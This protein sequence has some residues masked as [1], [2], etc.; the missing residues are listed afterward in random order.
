MPHENGS[1]STNGD[2]SSLVR[3]N[4]NLS[5]VSRMSNTLVIGDSFIVVP[6]L[7]SLVLSTGDKVLSSL[8]YSQ[9]VDL[10]SIGAIE[11]SDCLSVEAIPVGH[12]SV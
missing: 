6:D 3:G 10:S 1:L 7:D 8:S 2:N 12:L 11:H 9:G 4:T 5:D